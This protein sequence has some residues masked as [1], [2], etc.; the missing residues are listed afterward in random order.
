MKNYAFIACFALLFAACS[1]NNN[2]SSSGGAHSD[3][4]SVGAS[5]HD[6][7]SGDIFST[8]TIQVEYSP[9][10]KLQQQSIDNL[11]AFLQA[12]LH[13]TGG[14]TVTQSP[15]SSIAKSTVSI[16]DVSSFEDNNRTLFSGGSNLAVCV[17]AVDADYSSAGVAGVAFKNTSI[18]LLEKTI[19]ANSGGLAQASRVVVESSVLEHEFGHLLGLVNIGAGMV[20]PHEDDAHKAHCN[21]KNCLMYYEIETSGFLA[22]LTSAVP[23]LD[24]NCGNDLKS[25]GGK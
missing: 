9:G 15:V 16:G 25:N 12:H 23:Q 2:G 8:L 17:L 11:T 14:I 4:L 13:K 1:K 24:A 18:V 21:N 10:M 20:T 5:A 3:N 6:F 7:L 22:Q 19:Q